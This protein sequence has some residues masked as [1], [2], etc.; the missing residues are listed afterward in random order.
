MRDILVNAAGRLPWLSLSMEQKK[1]IDRQLALPF[2]GGK[3]YG[4][5]TYSTF[6]MKKGGKATISDWVNRM[7]ERI[8]R[9]LANEASDS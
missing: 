4:E 2:D 1:R 7:N 6:F 3:T 8:R 9:V 5:T